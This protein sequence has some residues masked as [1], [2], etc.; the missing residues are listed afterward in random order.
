[1]TYTKEDLKVGMVFKPSSDPEDDD[2][3]F[4]ITNPCTATGT[5]D[6][7]SLESGATWRDDSNYTVQKVL[8][9]LNNGDWTIT[10][11]PPPINPSYEI[12]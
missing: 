1:M 4:V 12:Y 5:V 2:E 11:N 8:D 7:D 9:R 10:H 6:F 3:G